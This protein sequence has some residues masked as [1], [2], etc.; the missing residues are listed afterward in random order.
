MLKT[1][2]ETIGIE[3]HL[4]KNRIREFDACSVDGEGYCIFRYKRG[5]PASMLAYVVWS[6]VFAMLPLFGL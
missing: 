4:I 5:V 3:K 2:L 1:R 6:S